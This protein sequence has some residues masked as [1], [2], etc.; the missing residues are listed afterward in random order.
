MLSASGKAFLCCSL[1]CWSAAEDCCAQ[2]GAA[3]QVH[4]KVLGTTEGHT[5]S[6]PAT[7][8]LIRLGVPKT[9]LVSGRGPLGQRWAHRLQVR[10]WRDYLR[11]YLCW[12][13]HVVLATV[14]HPVTSSVSG[15]RA[16]DDHRPQ[17]T[18][19]ARLPAIR[20][21]PRRSHAAAY[22]RDTSSLPYVRPHAS[23]EP[24]AHSKLHQVSTPL[25]PRTIRVTDTRRQAGRR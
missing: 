11:D 1:L 8:H 4:P 22:D 7:A 17:Y 16:S 15:F 10:D 14:V 25:Q 9:R 13:F 23:A 3:R 24:S 6:A 20:H 12:H 19:S 5:W 18:Q 21:A 2:V